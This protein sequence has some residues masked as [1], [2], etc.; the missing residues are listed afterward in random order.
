MRIPY[1][2]SLLFYIAE[3]KSKETKFYLV[4]FVDEF[5]YS[6]VEG[7]YIEELNPKTKDKV[8]VKSPHGSWK[9]VVYTSGMLR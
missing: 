1:S 4:W 7:K 6:V 8:H 2:V 9:G 5:K 3:S